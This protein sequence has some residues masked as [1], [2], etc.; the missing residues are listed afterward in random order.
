MPVGPNTAFVLLI[1]GFFG[2]YAE[3]LRPGR[4]FPGLAGAASAITGAFFLFASPFSTSGLLLLST[5]ALLLAAEAFFGPYFLFG[6][7]G[8][9]TLMAGFYFLI[10]PPRRLEP[11]LSLPLSA[12]FGLLTALLGAIAKRARRNKW[13]DL[14]R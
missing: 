6:A 12:L 3:F 10:P 9:V 14:K 2:I 11:A 1:F 8:A 7:L 13:A 5:A 4:L